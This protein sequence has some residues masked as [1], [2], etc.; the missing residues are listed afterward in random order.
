MCRVYY[1]DVQD[2]VINLY[3]AT[4]E[5]VS[6]RVFLIQEIMVRNTNPRNAQSLLWVVLVLV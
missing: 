6:Y 1:A 2:G 4:T 3:K 5:P